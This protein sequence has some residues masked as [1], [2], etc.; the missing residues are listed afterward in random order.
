[1]DLGL[2][3]MDDEIRGLMKIKRIGLSDRGVLAIQA[4]LI[5]RQKRIA[6]GSEW[7]AETFA[8]QLTGFLVAERLVPVHVAPDD[9]RREIANRIGGGGAY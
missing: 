8:D 5:A 3:G 1:M 6:E 7:P 2:A 9:L 4:A